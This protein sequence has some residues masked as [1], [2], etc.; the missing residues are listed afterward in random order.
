MK[1]SQ[2]K[3]E[4]HTLIKVAFK[5]DQVKNKVVADGKF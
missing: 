2:L 1:I 4:L 5:W 3:E